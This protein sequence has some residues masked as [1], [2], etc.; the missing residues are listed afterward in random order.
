[1]PVTNTS[2]PLYTTRRNFSNF[3]SANYRSLRGGRK[4]HAKPSG[5]F[6]HNVILLTGPE[7]EDV[8]CQGNRVF[9]QEN[10]HVMAFPLVKEWSDIG[11][12]LKI[13]EAFQDTIPPL[14]DFEL[15]QS[16]HTKV[17]K[18][19][20]AQRQYLT[21]QTGPTK[22]QNRW[23]SLPALPFLNIKR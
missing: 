10:G 18:P 3:R 6:S 20:L 13:K 4:Q 5:V 11:V 17:L 9:L 7:D 12:E 21:A 16:V 2:A 15:L 8:P 19:T 1:M 22:P 14:V 23:L